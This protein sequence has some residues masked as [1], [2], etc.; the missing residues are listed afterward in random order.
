M[1]TRVAVIGGGIV[2]LATARALSADPR[3]TVTV[4][5]KEADWGQHQTG[6]NSGVVHSGVSYK[7]GSLKASLCTAGAQSMVAFARE[8]GLPVDVCGKLIV[9]TESDELAG[10]EQLYQRGLANG[11]PVTRMTP[12]QAR[13]LE[14]AVACLAA[15]HVAS[16]A[17]IDYPAVTQALA[18]ELGTA[19]ADLRLGAQVVSLSADGSAVRIGV[20]HG[21]DLAADVVVNCA[22]LA[23]D[24]VAS[25]LG[26]RPPVRIIPFRGEYYVLRPEA[27]GLVRG[28]I[29]PVAD[30][31][32]PFLGV[33]LT[34]GIDQS[35]HVGPN[36]VL[37]LSREGYRR[38]DIALRDTIDVLRYAGFWRLARTYG[39]TG[40]DEVR[41]S[42]SRRR[43][44][45]SAARLVPDLTADDLVPAGSGVRAQAVRPDGQLVDD[46]LIMRRGRVLN[47][48]NAPS[49]AATSA[50]EI[51]Q[52]I[53]ASALDLATT[54]S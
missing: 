13:E 21:A 15:V 44:A 48:L 19:G 51:G 24:R 8:R 54:S 11:V 36:A 30:P 40:I 16:T 5:E 41:R 39:G 49:P 53:A 34:R 10:L 29:Y 32:L 50:L 35:V 4:L 1:I 27:A 25:L 52:R 6:H 18:D 31:R 14:P 47:V 28:L 38:G 26:G 33:H 12:A 42:F 17:V 43:F 3:T 37:A 20:A 23:S 45:A 46:F 7:P 2:G 9:A 22:G